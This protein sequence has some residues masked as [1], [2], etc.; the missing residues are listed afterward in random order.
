M[1]LIEEKG[2]YQIFLD[3]L[4]EVIP[5][6]QIYTELAVRF[7]YGT[8]ASCYRYIPEIVVRAQNEKDV[9]EIIALADL[10][11]IPITFSASGTSLSGQTSSNS[12]L[13]LLGDGFVG[14]DVIDDGLKIRLLPMTIGQNANNLLVPFGRKIGPDPATINTAR[15]GGIASNNSSG[16]CCGTKD[17]S[18]HTL[19][20]IKVIFADGAV[21]DTGDP[22]S[23]V[24]FRETHDTFLKGLLDLANRIKSQ[25]ELEAK[26]RHKYR[27][28]NTTGYGLN[29]L[30]D[31]DDPIEILSHLMIGAEGTL[32]FIS[33]ITYKT[34]ID[35][36][37][38]ASALIY[39][40][41]M[42]HCCDA[43]TAL[44]KAAIVDSVEL[45][46]APSIRC[47][48]EHITSDLPGFFYQ[49][50]PDNAACLLIETRADND[51]SLDEQIVQINKIVADF[52]CN[53]QSSFSKD[54]IVTDLYWSVRKGLLP[55]IGANRPVGSNLITEDVAFPIENLSKGVKALTLLFKK[56]HYSEA[57]IMGHALEGNLHFL[58]T[59]TFETA[60][61]ISN[62]N[63]FMHDLA[64]LVAVEYQGSLK[65]EHG[66]GRNVA[67]FVEV[68]W[69][70]DAYNIM[71][72]IKKLFDPKGIFNPDVIITDDPE[73]HLKNLKEVPEADP[74]IDQCME[75]G[76]CEPACPADGFTLT[77]RQR[78]VLW[79]QHEMLV[80]TGKDPELLSSIQKVYPEM[81]IETCAMTGM[82]ATRCPI[83]I[84]TGKMMK[85]LK[86][87]NTHYK[88]VNFA[89]DHIHTMTQGAR[90]GI[91]LSHMIGASLSKKISTNLHKRFKG[92]P[93]LPETLP[94]AASA[95]ALSK[96]I[97]SASTTEAGK[98]VVY[99]ISCV[100]RTFAEGIKGTTSVANDTLAL[101][102]KAGYKAI[103]PS[104]YQSLC[105]GQPFD[106]LKME[107]SA[108]KSVNKV[109]S[110]LLQAS[111]NGE[112]PIYADNA[113]C[114]F[115]LMEAQKEGLLDARL[116]IYDAATF[117]VENI[118]PKLTITNKKPALN[119]HIP[120]STTKMGSGTALQTLAGAVT[121]SLSLSGIACCGYAGNKGM[122]LPE[123]NQN[124][125]RLL[126]NNIPKGCDHGVSMSRTCQIGLTEHS[127]MS[128]ASIESL[129]NQCSN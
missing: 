32:G 80:K 47:V 10:Y 104:D 75:C 50:I 67:P 63:A 112:I 110:A 100:N 25:P 33:E 65:A 6:K 79:R 103:F 78:I 89:V 55:I 53:D 99:F 44:R 12:V 8:D 34:V 23:V 4:M 56:Y 36:P 14:G 101:F 51:K 83:G 94:K 30:V 86:V 62:Y 69:G 118:L 116:K 74:L 5:E 39:F 121:D 45:L 97:L 9:K 17:N 42:D 18:Y 126:N 95:S 107:L 73:L 66:T 120:C 71:R 68:E 11:L 125:L 122:F 117:L 123:L 60:E 81:G 27:L 31:F 57:I 64:Q 128:Y 26:I 43:V 129:L 102:Q 115:R 77:P 82:C 76:F 124:G 113:P 87:P 111:H 48:A 49:D 119:L 16:M 108:D 114:A 40:E 13:V 19:D 96:A 21:L 3:A 58:L 15:I 37:H 28:K 52:Y 7:A 22:K 91:K 41:S 105:C 1:A 46:D 29:A 93:V 59:P 127:G 90:I 106:S 61:E 2:N 92:I 84:D 109:N 72:D 54:P 35:H 38:K 20:S 24:Q 88:V 98:S 85:K 70:K